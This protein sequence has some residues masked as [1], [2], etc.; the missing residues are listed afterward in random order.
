MLIVLI[1][2]DAFVE[3]PNPVSILLLTPLDFFVFID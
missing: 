2:F 3:L 1:T